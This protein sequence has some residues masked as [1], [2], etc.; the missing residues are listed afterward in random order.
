MLCLWSLYSENICRLQSKTQ[1][2][3]T[4]L[5]C[6]NLHSYARLQL[7]VILGNFSTFTIHLCMYDSESQTLSHRKHFWPVSE[8][9]LGL[10]CSTTW[11]VRCTTWVTKEFNCAL[12]GQV[13][14]GVPLH[15]SYIYKPLKCSMWLLG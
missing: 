1:L 8:F 10:F 9:S 4:V 14:L 12:F 15:C 7:Q 3:M 2:T 13:I 5:H 11:I 6:L